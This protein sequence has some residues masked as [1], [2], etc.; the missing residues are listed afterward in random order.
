MK[1]DLG[2][3]TDSQWFWYSVRS[4]YLPMAFNIGVL[5][6]CIVALGGMSL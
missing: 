1:R 2:S 6:L 5:C 3:M 4:F